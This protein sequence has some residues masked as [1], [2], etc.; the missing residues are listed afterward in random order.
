M[1]T[2]EIEPQK[3]QLDADARSIETT[4]TGAV[5]TKSWDMLGDLEARVTQLAAGRKELEAARCNGQI[6]YRPFRR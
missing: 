1:N 5:K 6:S 3:A 4:I 2:A